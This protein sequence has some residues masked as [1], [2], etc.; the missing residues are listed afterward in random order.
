MQDTAIFEGFV[1]NYI[2]EAEVALVETAAVQIG[3]SCRANAE[4]PAMQLQNT[5]ISF[6]FGRIIF[7]PESVLSKYT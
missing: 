4:R 6:E 1:A 7:E 3:N 2:A 5:E